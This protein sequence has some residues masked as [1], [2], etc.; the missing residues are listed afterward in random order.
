MHLQ[1]EDES[2]VELDVT[3]QIGKFSPT[4]FV[5]LTN[6]HEINIHGCRFINAELF[7]DCIVSCK[8]LNKLIIISCS[9]FNEIHIVRMLPELKCLRYFDMDKSNEL[10][11]IGAFWVLSVSPNIQC[12]ISSPKM[13]WMM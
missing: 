10:S 4:L 12:I 9:Q 2:T 8:N 7:V 11:F 1:R 5:Y 3:S 6:I 13:L